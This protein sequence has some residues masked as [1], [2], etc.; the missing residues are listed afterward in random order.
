M[1]LVKY[2][3][4]LGELE[5]GFAQVFTSLLTYLN[6]RDIWSFLVDYCFFRA[7]VL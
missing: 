7:I 5:Y 4:V 6:F 2:F 1:I 3:L